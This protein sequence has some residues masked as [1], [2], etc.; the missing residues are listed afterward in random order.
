M[1][2]HPTVAII[3]S[4]NCR[5]LTIRAVDS[6]RVTAPDVGVVVVDNASTDGTTA[7]LRERFHG[8][9]D[10]TVIHS[11]ENLGFGGAVNLGAAA[12]P[13][14]NIVLLN[15]DARVRP[16]AIQRLIGVLDASSGPVLLGG[17]VRLPDGRID[18]GFA[19]QLPS[20][21][22]LICFAT[23]MS[24][25]LRDSRWLNPESLVG[26]E[27]N[28]PTGVGMVSGCFALVSADAWQELGGFDESYFMYAEDADLSIRASRMGIIPTVVPDAEVIHESGATS[29]SGKRE[30]LKLHGRST[31]LRTHWSRPRRTIG[32][33]LLQMGVGLRAL[34]DTMRREA[35][36]SWRQAW[37]ARARW[38]RGY[39][40]RHD[41]DSCVDERQA[42][43]Q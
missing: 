36:S 12:V 28:G 30:I 20:V 37:R 9:D 29:P 21:W 8:D 43:R 31:Y 5:D 18:P 2:D 16:G 3:V 22:S 26:M 24:T 38:R 4:Y 13:G 1:T 10:L 15:P 14:S 34:V 35:A 19:K 27:M 7:A 33:L 39:P 23:G 32:L 11:G 40:L 42:V 41:L 17:M 25:L 6:C